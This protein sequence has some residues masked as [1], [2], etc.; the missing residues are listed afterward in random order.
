MKLHQYL[1]DHQITVD[2]L[3]RISEHSPQTLRGWFK[4]E[5]KIRMIYCLV[6]CYKYRLLNGIPLDRRF[7]NKGLTLADHLE[8]YTVTLN[9][10]VELTGQHPT[11]LRNWFVNPRKRILLDILLDALTWARWAIENGLMFDL[12]SDDEFRHALDKQYI[13][14]KKTFVAGLSKV[15]NKQNRK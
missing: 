13:R 4:S 12:G 14:Q 5:K 3:T 7:D 15:I 8:A 6:A 9:E 1:R 10:L 2:D 11:N